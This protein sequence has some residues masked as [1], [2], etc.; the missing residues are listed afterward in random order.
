MRPSRREWLRVGL[1]A[2]VAPA[3]MIPQARAYDIGEIEAKLAKGN[4]I[5]GVTKDDLPTP[6]LL[7][8]LDAFEANVQRMASHSAPRPQG[9]RGP[10]GVRSE[11]GRWVSVS[12]RSARRRP[13]QWPELAACC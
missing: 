10:G 7:L 3:I 2:A 12:R 11:R 5:D 1:H 6:S 13:W 8:D 9:A 4:G